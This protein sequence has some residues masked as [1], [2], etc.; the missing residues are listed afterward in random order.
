MIGD[1]EAETFMIR[2][3]LGVI[4]SACVLFLCHTCYKV[5]RINHHA[6]A[7]AKKRA[8]RGARLADVFVCESY[9]DT[10]VAQEHGEH[11]GHDEHF[12]QHV[13]EELRVQRDASVKR[14][15]LQAQPDKLGPGP[16]S[17]IGPSQQ[18]RLSI[19]M[20]G[21]VFPLSGLPTAR[22]SVRSSIGTSRRS[23]LGSSTRSSTNRVEALAE[24]KA[25]PVPLV[26]WDCMTLSG[27]PGSTSPVQEPA[28]EEPT[29]YQ[30]VQVDVNRFASPPLAVLATGEAR[31]ATI[32]PLRRC[33][34]LHS[35][36]LAATTDA[37]E[38]V[39]LEAAELRK[40]KHHCLLRMFA[41]VADQPYGE[42]GLLSEL[43]T[44][45]LA[46]L[47]E[48]SP[49]RLT[50]ANGLLALATDVAAGLAHLHGLGL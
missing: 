35:V 13:D 32:K 11:A 3:M 49:V 36:V 10:A 40:L 8:E 7:K 42:V 9:Q 2:L 26:R 25:A 31:V 15:F 50:W 18:R 1:V 12:W 45:S 21:W 4:G 38:A 17:S 27:P 41:V 43:T 14:R 23:S 19:R 20:A 48:T 5:S 46:S 16:K 6:A 44:G 24:P 47:L 34:M 29:K 39:L 30:G 28:G 37:L 33:F 22:S